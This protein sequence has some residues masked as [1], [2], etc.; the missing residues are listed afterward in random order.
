MAGGLESTAERPFSK[1]DIRIAAG[2]LE[3]QL[4]AGV[5][6]RTAVLRMKDLQ[7]KH[8]RTWAG[9]S[10][11]IE[12][13]GSLSEALVNVWPESVLAA[14]QAGERSGKVSEVMGHI[15]E[16]LGVMDEVRKVLM[17]LLYPAMIILAGIGVFLFFMVVVVPTLTRG[18]AKAAEAS[19]VIA[20]SQWMAK[21]ATENGMLIGITVAGAIISIIGFFMVPSNRE[22]V[23]AFIDEIPGLGPAVRSMWFGAWS[24]QMAMLDRAGSIPVPEA[25]RLSAGMLPEIYRSGLLMMA[26]EAGR[27]GLANA[28]TADPEDVTDP[29][30]KWP[31]YITMCFQMAHSTGNLGDKLIK[32]APALIK[33]G[34]RAIGAAAKTFQVAA[35]MISGMLVSIPMVG[36]FTAIAGA[37]KKA[38]A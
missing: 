11:H 31:F 3:T 22:S 35:L 30:S 15:D 19:P 38:F 14:V 21:V 23:L 34:T 33:E 12:S 4:A 18:N 32:F 1:A 20:V 29:R 13:G 25:L 24:Y 5:N 28:A 7:K 6:V 8:A 17:T 16:A 9:V 37:L 2:A 10:A 27:A 26:D 36:Y